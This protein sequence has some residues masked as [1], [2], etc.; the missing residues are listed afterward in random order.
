MTN[1]GP[2]KSPIMALFTPKKWGYSGLVQKLAVKISKI[3]L[4]CKKLIEHSHYFSLS[5]KTQKNSLPS[6]DCVI[7]NAIRYLH[8][9][10]LV[11]AGRAILLYFHRK[12]SKKMLNRHETVFF[13]MISSFHVE[14]A[15]NNTFQWFGLI[16]GKNLKNLP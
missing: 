14:K 11:L 12:S 2:Q 4:N 16:R 7:C 5:R 1:F 15:Q 9:T 8:I 13:H 6:Q 10:C 3:V